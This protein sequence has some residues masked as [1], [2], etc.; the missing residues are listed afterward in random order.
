MRKTISDIRLLGECRRRDYGARVGFLDKMPP[1]G[2]SLAE[3]TAR[4]TIEQISGTGSMKGLIPDR[5][6]SCKMFPDD[7]ISLEHGFIIDPEPEPEQF[8]AE[9]LELRTGKMIYTMKGDFTSFK[10]NQISGHAKD[11]KILKEGE[12]FI[13]RPG[14]VYLVE[15]FERIRLPQNV[16]GISDARSGVARIGCSGGAATGRNG[17]LESTFF[18][19]EPEYVYF[20]IVPHAFPIILKYRESRPVQVRFRENGFGPLNAEE[21][22]KIYGEDV[23]LYKKGKLVKFSHELLDENGLTLR[24]KTKGYYAQRENVNTPIDIT[25][26]DYYDP[27]EFFARVEDGD[28]VEIQPR[29]LYLFG[30]KET[31]V[32]ADRLCGD[33]VRSPDTLGQGISNN[34]ARFFGAGFKGEITMEVWNYRDNPYKA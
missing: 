12:E 34:F 14:E 20:K 22:R 15:S 13:A 6:I 9:S 19:T 5:G 2:L 10:P 17:V 30:S 11:C 21:I 25:R 32:L 3:R 23:G 24:V 16:Y 8:Q 18:T 27:E 28:E 31:I 4:I 7:R 29:R 1:K 33:L 26:K